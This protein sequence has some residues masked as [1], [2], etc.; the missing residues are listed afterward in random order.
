MHGERGRQAI[1]LL[2]EP[3]QDTP[4]V[5]GIRDTLNR[6]AEREV[7][8]KRRER[9]NALS[10]RG[11]CLRGVPALPPYP[12]RCGPDYW[13]VLVVGIYPRRL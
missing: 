2:L 13:S 11:L 12:D 4:N 10:G 3:L 1:A 6:E 5:D 7:R 8:L 9:L